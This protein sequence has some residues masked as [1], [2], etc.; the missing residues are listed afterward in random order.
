M[1]FTQPASALAAI[2]ILTAP[3]GAALLLGAV[4]AVWFYSL[5]R[6][7]LTRI[8]GLLARRRALDKG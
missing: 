8:R 5:T 1:Q 7:P 3:V 2:R 4:E 6:V